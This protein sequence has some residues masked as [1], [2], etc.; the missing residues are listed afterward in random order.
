MAKGVWSIV[1]PPDASDAVA[2]IQYSVVNKDASTIR[3]G[4]AVAVHSSGTGVVLANA[5]VAGKDACGIATT[6]IAPSAAGVVQTEGQ[7]VL[8][9]W[10]YAVGSATLAARGVYYLDTIG[11][12][13]TTTPPSSVGNIWQKVGVEIDTKTLLIELGPTI[14]L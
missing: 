10:T 3:A 4:Q 1:G 8:S 13:I 12:K 5:T 7:L 6:D 11:G 2:V 9:D 14:L